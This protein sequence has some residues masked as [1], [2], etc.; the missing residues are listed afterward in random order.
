MAAAGS[1]VALATSSNSL[2]VW[3]LS[4]GKK[5]RNWDGPIKY[6]ASV[7]EGHVVAVSEARA[8]RKDD[9]FVWS[10]RSGRSIGKVFFSGPCQLKGYVAAGDSKGMVHL[11]DVTNGWLLQVFPAHYKEVATMAFSPCGNFLLTGG[12]DAVVH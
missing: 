5:M 11:W 6:V 8:G 4:S 3:D 1:Q 2:E 12:G 7:D 9:V 10:W